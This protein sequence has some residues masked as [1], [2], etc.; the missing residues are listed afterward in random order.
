MGLDSLA[1]KVFVTAGLGGMSGAQPK[2]AKIAGCIGVIAEISDTALL[3]RHQQG[4][5]DVYSK[6]LEEIVNWIKE[7]REK[8]EAIS[9]GYLGNV[10]DLW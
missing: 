9:I 4:W 10:V 2:A 5:L 1:G 3:K 8:K 7:Y 6:D